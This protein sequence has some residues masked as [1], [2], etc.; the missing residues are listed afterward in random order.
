MWLSIISDIGLI[1]IAIVGGLWAFYKFRKMRMGEGKLEIE[2]IPAVYHT[3]K[4][5]VIEVT[6]RLINNGSA[7]IYTKV[8]SNPKCLFEAKAIQNVF[9]DSAIL[10]DDNNLLSLFPP[11]EFL[12]DLESWLPEKPYL[13]EPGTTETI[14]VVFSTSHDGLI[15][16]KASFV[17]KDDNLWTAKKIID[18]R[19]T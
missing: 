14:N 16:I 12:K 19:E 4:S 11:I 1:F 8:P 15:F 3:V 6:M 7:A 2:L 17:D 13:L 10:W 9:K 5:K 18:L